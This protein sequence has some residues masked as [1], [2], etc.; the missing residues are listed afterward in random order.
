MLKHVFRGRLVASFQDHEHEGGDT[1]SQGGIKNVV[2]KIKIQD[3]SMQMISQRN[4]QEQGSKFQESK[5]ILSKGYGSVNLFGPRCGLNAYCTGLEECKIVSILLVDHALSHALTATADVPIV[6]LQQSQKTV[7]KVLNTKDPIRFKIDR[8]TI[9]YIVDMFRDALQLLVETLENPFIKKD[10]I[11]YPRFTKLIIADLMKKFPSIAPRLEEEYHSIK[12]D[13]PLGRNFLPP[14][15]DLSSLEEF[16]NKSVVSKP[17][18]KKPIVKTS[19]AK[20]SDDKPK[21]VNEEMD[22]SLERATTTATSLDAEQNR[23][24]ISK[25]QSKATLNE[26]GSQGTTL[27]GSPRC[28][29]SIGDTVA[30]TRSKRV[31]KISNDLLLIGVNTPL[32]GEDSLKLT[33]LMELYTKL[34]QRVLDLETTKTTQAMEIESLKRRVKKLERRKRSRTHRLKRLY[35][36]GLSARVEYFKDEGLGEEDASK[37]GRIPDIDS[38]EDIYLVNVHMDKDIFGFNDSDGDEVIIEDA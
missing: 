5:L 9:T 34:Q 26:P 2:L 6:Y 33:K 22:N 16:M 38:N 23:D 21:A 12:D 1:R 8:D 29:E 20:A 24:N 15:P 11:L 17:M 14:K 30:Q 36:V 3:H 18:V 31:S 27:G 28:Q 37:Q 13:V 10:S 7:N 4:S 25:I 35:K 32:S 19:E